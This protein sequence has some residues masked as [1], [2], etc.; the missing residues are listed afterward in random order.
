MQRNRGVFCAMSDGKV[1]NQLCYTAHSA[2]GAT[3]GESVEE[4]HVTNF[5]QI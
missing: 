4:W 3:L 2:L 5:R 1:E